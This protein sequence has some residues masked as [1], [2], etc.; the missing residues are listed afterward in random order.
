MGLATRTMRSTVHVTKARAGHDD[1]SADSIL[2]TVPAASREDGCRAIGAAA[3]RRARQQSHRPASQPRELL[4]PVGRGM[5]PSHFPQS[6]LDQVACF[7]KLLDLQIRA[8][9]V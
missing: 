9:F 2:R 4:Q 1:F 8:D 5:L 6:V 7:V 3:G